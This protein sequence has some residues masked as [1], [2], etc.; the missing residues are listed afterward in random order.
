MDRVKTGVR[1]A[2]HLAETIGPDLV[3]VQVADHRGPTSRA[4][5]RGT[6]IGAE[7]VHA[8]HPTRTLAVSQEW[9]V[10]YVDSNPTSAGYYFGSRTDLPMPEIVALG[11][12]IEQVS[13]CDLDQVAEAPKAE[14]ASSGGHGEPAQPAGH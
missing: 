12:Q 11:H 9:E 5:L 14:A 7:I 13:G 6:A 4:E 3:I 1:V 8:P 2:R 10:R